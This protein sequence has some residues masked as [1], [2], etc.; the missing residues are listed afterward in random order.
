MS[1]EVGVSS[2]V[3]G[4]G[5]FLIKEMNKQKTCFSCSSYLCNGR[6]KHRPVNYLL[7]EKVKNKQSNRP[8]NTN[9][10]VV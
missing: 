8:S 7:Y 3:G 6:I 5:G 9:K 10:G 2:I 4:G 1:E